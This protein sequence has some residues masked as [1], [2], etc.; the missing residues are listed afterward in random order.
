MRTIV[1]DVS[2]N[3]PGRFLADEFVQIDTNN[4]LGLLEIAQLRKVDVVMSDQTDRVIPT[5]A[6]LNAY[7]GLRGIRPETA[8]VFTNKLEMRRT[9]ERNGGNRVGMPEYAEV[10]TLPETKQFASKWGFPLV[11]KPKISQSSIGV[12]KVENESELMGSFKGA[13]RR[14][15]DGKILVEQFIKGTEVT[16]EGISLGGKNRTLAVSEKEH[17]NFN[18]CIARRLA[19]PAYLPKAIFERIASNAETVVDLLGL[20]DGLT[21][22]E[23]RILDGVPYLVEVA[24]RGGG[25]RISSFIVPHV[26]GVDV[27]DLLIKKLLGLTADIPQRLSR[28]ANLEFLDFPPG[29]VRTIEG[30]AQV[31]EEHAADEIRLSFRPGDRIGQPND[32]KTRLGYFISLGHTRDEVERKAQRVRNLV[33]VRYERDK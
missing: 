11:L 25:N 22:A 19:Y 4:R 1:A 7:L 5:V 3:A 27:Y 12:F 6:F 17:Y 26:S 23:Y 21:H 29:K 9:I 10:T 15:A 2:H 33:K 32:D 18:P 13:M 8:L 16:V 28:A 30:L 31:T 14:S 20:Q 24:A